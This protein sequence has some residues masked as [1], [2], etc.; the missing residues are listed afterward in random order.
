MNGPLVEADGLV[1]RAGRRTILD[2]PILRIEPGEV[3]C[4]LGGNGAG[5][6]TLLKVLTGFV[7]PSAGRVR[8]LGEDV[9]RLGASGLCRLR[10]RA[11]YLPQPLAA[12]SE[13]P[14][15]VREVVA[16]GRTGLVRPGRRLRPDDWRCVDDWLDR[17]GLRTL[18]GQRY[19]DCSGGEQRKT[20]IAK[21]LAQEPEVL[22]LDEPTANLDLRSREELVGMIEAIHNRDGLT[23]ILVCH[24]LDVLPGTTSRVMLLEE[25]RVE[26]TGSPADVLSAERATAL[27]G[28]GLE[29]LRRGT[30]YTVVPATR[31]GR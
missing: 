25:G 6:T 30:R 28:P 3:F 29:V 12:R 21:A 16:I 10:R 15:T 4:I 27:Y 2:V 14:L 24:E 26:G 1:V 5:K 8:V 9:P 19:A 13:L 23:V 20:L 22:L 31:E 17:L 7:H 18:A 11:A